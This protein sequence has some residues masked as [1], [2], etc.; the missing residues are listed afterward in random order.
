VGGRV[1]HGR[2]DDQER[3][4]GVRVVGGVGWT[5]GERDIPGVLDELG[6]LGD[7]YGPA[8]DRKRVHVDFADRPSSG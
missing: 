4:I 1:E 7:R 6:E 5:F 3:E 8:V 2:A